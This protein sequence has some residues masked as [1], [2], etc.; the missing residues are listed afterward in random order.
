MIVG[1]IALTGAVLVGGLITTYLWKA[2]MKDQMKHAAAN[3][4]SYFPTGR[5]T[6]KIFFDIF[7]GFFQSNFQFFNIKIN[8]TMTMIIQCINWW[9]RSNGCFASMTSMWRPVCRKWFVQ[10]SKMRPKMWPKATDQVQKRYSMDCQG[11]C[12]DRSLFIMWHAVWIRCSMIINAN[13]D[14]IS[15]SCFNINLHLFISIFIDVFS[16]SHIFSVTD[17]ARGYCVV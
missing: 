8:S 9:K 17:A 4:Q 11:E 14:I 6:S 7:P 12:R 10:Q 3:D 15:I 16:L 5:Q 2:M 13:D 1:S